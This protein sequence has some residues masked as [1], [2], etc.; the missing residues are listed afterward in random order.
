MIQNSDTLMNKKDAMDSEHIG[1]VVDNKDPEYKRRLKIKIPKVLEADNDSL[2]WAYPHNESSWGGSDKFGI[3]CIPKIGSKIIVRFIDG[4][5]HAPYY[6]YSSVTKVPEEFRESYPDSYGFK[7]ESGNILIINEKN[8]SFKFE[9]TSGFKFSIT[10]SGD[11]E[12]NTNGNGKVNSKNLEF[13]SENNVNIN[14]TNLIELSTNYIKLI[15][16]TIVN[17]TSPAVKTT[18]DIFDSIRSM[19]MDRGIFNSHT[20]TGVHGETSPPKDK[21]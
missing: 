6:D 8:S 21:Q 12:L 4:D 13:N 2:P 19:A 3:I 5:P 7:D 11:W 16:E 18:G 10:E 1:T 14:A 20:H 15:A 17:I 9:H